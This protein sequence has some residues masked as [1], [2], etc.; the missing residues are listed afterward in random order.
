MYYRYIL[1]K[2]KVL[3]ASLMY[4]LKILIHTLIYKCKAQSNRFYRISKVSLRPVREL[5]G[6]YILVR[7][8]VKMLKCKNLEFII[9]KYAYYHIYFDIAV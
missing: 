3:S 4:W 9:R 5:L 8:Q 6:C 7:K 2:H 1:S